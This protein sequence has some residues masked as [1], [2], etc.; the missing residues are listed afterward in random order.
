LA[1]KR[2]VLKDEK[3]GTLVVSKTVEGRGISGENKESWAK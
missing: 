2:A 1:L 3:R